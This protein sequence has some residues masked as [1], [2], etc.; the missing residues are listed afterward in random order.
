MF[1]KEGRV[2]RISE[3]YPKLTGLGE[4]SQKM[5]EKS[6]DYRL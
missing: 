6:I 5:F 1:D 2:L 4:L 3:V